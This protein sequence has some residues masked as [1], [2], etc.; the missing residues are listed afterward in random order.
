MH[1]PADEREGDECDRIEDGANLRRYLNQDKPT[2]RIVSDGGFLRETIAHFE[3]DNFF[4]SGAAAEAWLAGDA[5]AF[6]DAYGVLGDAAADGF[7]GDVGTA[8]AG[9]DE[10]YCATVWRGAGDGC[11]LCGVSTAGHD[12]LFSGGRRGF[13]LAGDDFEPVPGDRKSVV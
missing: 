4:Q 12:Q 1:V 10:V 13:D 11:V 3:R 5:A 8:G 7:D 2:D 6:G 9:A